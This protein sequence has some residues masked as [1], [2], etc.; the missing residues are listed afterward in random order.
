MAWSGKRLGA[1]GMTRKR[2][3]QS[4]PKKGGQ[5]ELGSGGRKAPKA[6]LG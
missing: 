6:P 4:E 2:L 3:R 1:K 5:A